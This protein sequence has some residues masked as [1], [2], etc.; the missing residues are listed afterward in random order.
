MI[1]G[2]PSAARCSSRIRPA[3]D[4][5]S[6]SRPSWVSAP[7][8][9]PAM[10]QSKAVRP[11]LRVASRPASAT[12]AARAGRPTS[13]SVEARL[14][15]ARPIASASPTASDSSSDSSIFST[16]SRLPLVVSQTPSVFRSCACSSRKPSSSASWRPRRANS[17]PSMSLPPSICSEAAFEY[18]ST[19]P[20]DGPSSSR[21]AIARPSV[22]EPRSLS[23]ERQ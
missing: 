10:N 19:R 1:P 8:R 17:L 18:A 11:R 12:A 20:A 2:G 22:W 13:T 14:L 15:Y 4:S 23:P 5:A 9:L 21:I 3:R 6:S 7:A 16:P